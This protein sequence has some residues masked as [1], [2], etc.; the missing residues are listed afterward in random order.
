M[1]SLLL[2][3]ETRE[4]LVMTGL[5]GPVLLIVTVVAVLDIKVRLLGERM[6]SAGV[7]IVLA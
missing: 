7:K 1:T 2:I 3:V 4:R 6:E 5:T